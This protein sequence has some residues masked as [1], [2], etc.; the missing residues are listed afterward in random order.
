MV[1]VTERVL[2]DSTAVPN[3]VTSYVLNLLKILQGSFA[4]NRREPDGHDFDEMYSSKAFSRNFEKV[5]IIFVMSVFPFGP[6]G[7]TRL[8]PGG[9]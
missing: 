5:T 6:H 7:T 9:L 8:L 3:Y 2:T 4:D 1:T